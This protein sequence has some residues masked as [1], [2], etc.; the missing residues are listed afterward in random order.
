MQPPHPHPRQRLVPENCRFC[1]AAMSQVPH[2][3]A[4]P[5]RPS[6]TRCGT[7]RP[8]SGDRASARRNRVPGKAGQR[9]GQ[10]V[11]G[12]PDRPTSTMVTRRICIRNGCRDDRITC[13]GDAIRSDARGIDPGNERRERLRAPR[14]PGAV[15]A[16]C[17]CLVPLTDTRRNS[18]ESSMLH[19]AERLGG[20][21]GLRYTPLTWV[22]CATSSTFIGSER[23][24]PA[25]QPPRSA[26]G[27]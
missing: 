5:V 16:L 23:L 7:P 4:A 17:I 8:G 21:S 10:P 24:C 22:P 13:T 18:H 11:P 2:R 3:A 12:R 26:R 20:D 15:S 14:T 9:N 19:P 25:N 1:V 6:V 27:T